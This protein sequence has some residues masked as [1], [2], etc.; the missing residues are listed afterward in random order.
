MPKY[1]SF[2]AIYVIILFLSNKNAIEFTIETKTICAKTL[3]LKIHTMLLNVQKIYRLSL[4]DKGFIIYGEIR[5][6]VY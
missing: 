6:E 2:I 1:L 4:L 3:R 5:V